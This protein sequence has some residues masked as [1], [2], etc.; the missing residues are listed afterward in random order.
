[1]EIIKRGNIVDTWGKSYRINKEDSVFIC[2]F[3]LDYALYSNEFIH[4]T[5]GGNTL[6]IF[7][8]NNFIP[9]YIEYAE[10]NIHAMCAYVGKDLFDIIMEDVRV[11]M[12]LCENEVRERL[13]GVL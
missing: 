4:L 5:F 13:A 2:Y 6:D 3:N 1:V 9:G 11:W 8:V 12:K 7:P 10:N